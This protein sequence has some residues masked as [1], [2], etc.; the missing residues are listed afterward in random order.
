MWCK[1]LGFFQRGLLERVAKK[2]VNIT[3]SFCKSTGMLFH[4]HSCNYGDKNKNCRLQFIPS[5][6]KRNDFL[7]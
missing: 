1:I 7:R 2:S 6:S 4:F 3:L 5:L